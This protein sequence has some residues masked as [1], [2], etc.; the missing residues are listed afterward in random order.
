MLSPSSKTSFLSVVPSKLLNRHQ[1][2][3]EHDQPPYYGTLIRKDVAVTQVVR[4][5]FSVE[6]SR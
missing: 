1:P 2:V 6:S 3:W 4:S 5:R